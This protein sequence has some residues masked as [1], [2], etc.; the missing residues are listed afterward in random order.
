MSEI[1]RVGWELANDKFAEG[2]DRAAALREIRETVAK[3]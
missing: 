3:L 1:V 2:R